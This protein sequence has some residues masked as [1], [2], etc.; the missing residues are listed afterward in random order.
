[1]GWHNGLH[2]SV[3]PLFQ[4]RSAYISISSSLEAAHS[5]LVPD[6]VVQVGFHDDMATC[7]CD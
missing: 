5:L 6:G 7:P 1:M 3:L 2:R 4:L